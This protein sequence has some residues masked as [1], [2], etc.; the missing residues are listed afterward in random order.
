M[1][2]DATWDIAALF[3]NM[4]LGKLELQSVSRESPEEPGIVVHDLLLD[5]YR[6]QAEAG[7]KLRYWH[8]QFLNGFLKRPMDVT[9]RG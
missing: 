8:M 7:K 4:S 3:C 5:F 6:R 1:E 2:E 9:P